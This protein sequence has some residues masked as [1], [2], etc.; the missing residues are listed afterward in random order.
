MRRI[1]D[2]A[3]SRSARHDFDALR[4]EACQLVMPSADSSSADARCTGARRGAREAAMLAVIAALPNAII[5]ALIGRSW[6]L[7]GIGSVKQR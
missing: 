2:E 4:R 6:R 5:D 3:L 1:V 7:P